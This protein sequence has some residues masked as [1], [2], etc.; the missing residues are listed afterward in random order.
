MD[1]LKQIFKTID[2]DNQSSGKLDKLPISK[3]VNQ[4]HAI[5]QKYSA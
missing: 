5:L 3:T 2:K 1:Y 4:I